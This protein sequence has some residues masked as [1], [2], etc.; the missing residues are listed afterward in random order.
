MQPHAAE[1]SRSPAIP[2]LAS[3]T[4]AENERPIGRYDYED[5]S[6]VRIVARGEIDTEEALS[7]IETLIQLKRTELSRHK[8]SSPPAAKPDV[9]DAEDVDI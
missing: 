3:I 4:V 1:P 6:Y 2:S 7:M 8:R 9:A 5:G